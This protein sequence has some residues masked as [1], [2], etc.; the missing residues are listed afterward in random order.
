MTFRT[1]TLIALAVTAVGCTPPVVRSPGLKAQMIPIISRCDQVRARLRAKVRAAPSVGDAE[2][3][4]A[5]VHSLVPLAL[6]TQ[7]ACSA[8][9]GELSALAASVPVPSVCVDMLESKARHSAFTARVMNTIE[10]ASKEDQ[11]ANA[12]AGRDVVRFTRACARA[13]RTADPEA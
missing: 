12:R 9:Q 6:Q 11:A 7:Q 1:M 3:V 10:R 2:A 4:G 8:A 13:I 5:E